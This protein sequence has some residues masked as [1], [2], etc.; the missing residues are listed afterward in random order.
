MSIFTQFKLSLCANHTIT[1]LLQRMALHQMMVCR[2]QRNELYRLNYI[3]ICWIICWWIFIFLNWIYFLLQLLWCD[4]FEKSQFKLRTQCEYPFE[5][6]LNEMW[7][8]YLVT[9]LKLKVS[10][11][12][13][14]C[15][16]VSRSRYVKM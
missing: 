5:C 14:F 16:I 15:H 12:T 6:F 2:K 10:I 1:D 3:E 7:Q 11:I 8:P 13:F 9:T 4:S